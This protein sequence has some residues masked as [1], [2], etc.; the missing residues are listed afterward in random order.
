MIN[1]AA[2]VTV[3]AALLVVPTGWTVF[4]QS[5]Y[6]AVRHLEA[7]Q[8]GGHAAVVSELDALAAAN[9]L[10]RVL[11]G[12]QKD[13]QA[14]IDAAPDLERGRRVITAA[15]YALEAGKA[16]AF[17]EWKWVSVFRHTFG[18]FVLPGGGMTTP[19][20]PEPYTSIV[21]KPPPQLIE[22][23]CDLLRRHPEH[24]TIGHAWHLAALAAAQ[25][26]GDFEFLIGSPFDVR[27]N[28]EEEIEHLNHSRALFPDEAR[29]ML[30]QAVALEW[31]TYPDSRRPQMTPRAR[32]AIDAYEDL[33]SD[34]HVG[35]EANVRLGSLFL[36]AGRHADALK[37]LTRADR[38]TRDPH[39]VY[40]AAFLSGRAHEAAG[41]VVEAEQSYQRALSAVP[42]GQSAAIAL[43]TLLVGA[44]RHADAARLIDNMMAAPAP[45]DPWREYG[46]ADFRFWPQLIAQLREAGT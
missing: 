35:A 24:A 28:E 6:S 12:L 10:G 41:R 23:G 2:R 20:S 34:D 31:M 13:A 39:L 11:E 17:S 9:D 33:V 37:A 4:G 22:W 16:G 42:R 1:R 36:R 29:F 32:D 44:D 8:A 43:G 38:A 21:W 19:N 30:G 40:L 14:W 3:V 7:Y 18:T 5:G 46:R 25:R 15:T 26:A 27:H 45:V